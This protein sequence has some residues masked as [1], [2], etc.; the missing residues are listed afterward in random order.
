MKI[1]GLMMAA[2]LV[3]LVATGCTTQMAG[4]E[5]DL[6]VE[7]PAPA[8]EVPTPTPIAADPMA[9]D[10]STAWG[11][12]LSDFLRPSRRPKP[13]MMPT[14]RPMTSTSAPT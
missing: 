4:E 14:C 7:A 8:A 2:S 10:T 1:H 9:I 5:P 6:Y 13:S 3:A 11:A 12:Y